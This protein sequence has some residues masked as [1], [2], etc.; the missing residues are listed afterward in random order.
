MCL[1]AEAADDV[2]MAPTP[3]SRPRTVLNESDAAPRRAYFSFADSHALAYLAVQ[4]S[5]TL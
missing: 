1:D 3:R 4:M 5:D 2:S